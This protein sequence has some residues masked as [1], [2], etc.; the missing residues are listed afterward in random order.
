MI[1]RN[2]IFG[3]FAAMWQ[4]ERRCQLF[5][6]NA[7]AVDRLRVSDML[8]VGL[9][10]QTLVGLWKKQPHLRDRAS[11]FAACGLNYLEHALMF[12]IDARSGEVL[13]YWEASDPWQEVAERLRG[14]DHAA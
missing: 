9:P 8:A 11:D 12:V 1:M 7:S 3:H 13:E 14:A 6:E 10:E 2:Q 4:D 5:V